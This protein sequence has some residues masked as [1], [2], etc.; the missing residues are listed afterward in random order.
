VEEKKEEEEEEARI[1][2]RI[3]LFGFADSCRGV[4]RL[5]FIII[6]ACVHLFVSL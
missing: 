4:W 6:V 3:Y 1:R 5:C 2:R